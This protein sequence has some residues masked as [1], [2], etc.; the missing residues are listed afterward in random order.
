MRQLIRLPFGPEPIAFAIEAP[1]EPDVATAR[2]IAA[3]QE[4]S[5]AILT[6]TQCGA[7][8]LVANGGAGGVVVTASP[9]N[10]HS[11]QFPWWPKD[12]YAATRLVLECTVT[13]RPG[14]TLAGRVGPRE[15]W[16]SLLLYLLILIVWFV[17]LVALSVGPGWAIATTL[18]GG[19][20][21]A[22]NLRSDQVGALDAAGPISESIGRAMYGSAKEAPPIAGIEIG[23]TRHPIG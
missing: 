2:I 7:W 20:L 17:L 12:D 21:A 22:A 8:R 10:R 1:C 18:V 19:G 23:D 11:T 5:G 3:F 6:D 15:P 9:H 4:P 14:S 16:W 13:R